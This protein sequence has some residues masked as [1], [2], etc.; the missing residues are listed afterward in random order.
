V[1]GAHKCTVGEGHVLGDCRRYDPALVDTENIGKGRAK[2]DGHTAQSDGYKYRGREY[3]LVS[4]KN[5]HRA[6]GDKVGVDLVANTD[7]L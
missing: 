3:G 2:D 6:V 7:Q 4:W 1:D 5:S